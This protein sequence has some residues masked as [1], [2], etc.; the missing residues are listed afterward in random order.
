MER[1][2]L[3]QKITEK[4]KL[5]TTPMAFDIDFIPLGRTKSKISGL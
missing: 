4:L 5:Y 2:D 1:F 3:H